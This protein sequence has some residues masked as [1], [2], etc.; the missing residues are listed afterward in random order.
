MRF[1]EPQHATS[2]KRNQIPDIDLCGEI[3][4][5]V[6][7]SIGFNFIHGVCIVHH[8]EKYAEHENQ[9]TKYYPPTYL[10]HEVLVCITS[11]KK[12]VLFDLLRHSVLPSSSDEGGQANHRASI[13][14]TGSK[15]TPS[16]EPFPRRC[17]GESFPDRRREARSA[18]VL[19]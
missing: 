5:E 14:P 12:D 15:Q 1:T 10:P 13:L 18:N 6:S 2:E 7:L 16:S 11:L 8:L 17:S 3:I 9:R 19:K 4:K